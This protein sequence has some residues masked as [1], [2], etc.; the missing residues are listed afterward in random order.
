MTTQWVRRRRT[1]VAV[2]LA[3]LASGG[4]AVA[5]DR[6]VAIVEDT[7]GHVVGVEP[8]D[9]LR[10]G[11]EIVLNAD[12]GLI[13]S[14]LNSCQRENIRGGKVVIG[15]VQSDV[16]GGEVSRRRVPCD[17]AALNLTPEQA[18]QSATLVFRDPLKEKGIDFLLKTRQPI[19]IA[20]DVTEVTLEQLETTHSSRTIK[21][22]KGVA[23]LTADRGL[24]DQGGLYRLTAGAKIITFRVGKEATD[25][26]MPILQ[27]AIRI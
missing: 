22:T 27:R 25:N 24:L 14:Y 7:S 13:V 26:P 10:A 4:V 6:T 15:E 17:A 5:Q 8:L 2:L 19:V 9:L 1:A 20:P 12:S 11:R 21:V 16:K 3:L 23:D 18:N